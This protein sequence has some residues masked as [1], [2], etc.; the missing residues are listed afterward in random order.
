MGMRRYLATAFLARLAAE[1]VTVAVVMLVLART[2]DAAP[3]AYVLAA[4]TAPHVLAAPLAGTLAA[5]TPR[6]RMFYCGALAGFAAAVAALALLA[7]RVPL[8]VALAVA[9]AGG[10]CGPVVTGGLSSLIA[11]LTGPGPRRD[12]AYGLDATVYNA[13]SVAGPVLVGVAAAAAG[14]DTAM[15]LLAAVA[16]ASAVAAGT[17]PYARARATSAT[18]TGPRPGTG[19]KAK[20]SAA[21]GPDAEADPGTHKGMGADSGTATGPGGTS[22]RDGLVAG[23]VALWRVAELRAIT[24]ATCLAFLGVGALTTTTVLLAGSMGNPAAGSWLITAFALGAL[25]GSLAAARWGTRLPAARQAELGLFGIGLALGAAALTG[26][27][28]AA[29]ALY[30][31]AGVCD[32]P[33]LAATLRIR[34]EHAPEHARAQVFTVGAGLKITAAAAGAGLAGLAA[35]APPA[36]LLLGIAA[37]QLAAA[38]LCRALRPRRP[39]TQPHREHPAA[40]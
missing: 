2:G 25:A 37:L 38:A 12:L 4:W 16:L 10:C 24:A 5:R 40:A 6:P 15:G 14:A 31:V 13:A 19:G 8:P 3:G 17:L 28:V 30:A 32:G 39:A 9:V 20:T 27:P 11:G 34:A 21:A 35:T 7:G 29:A 23:L 33:V 26:S 36:L 1:G 22:M 18:G